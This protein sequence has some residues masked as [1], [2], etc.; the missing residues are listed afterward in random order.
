[1]W[2]VAVQEV[3]VGSDYGLPADIYSFGI[4]LWEAWSHDGAGGGCAGL[5]VIL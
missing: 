4:V 1:M 2:L 3:L 5:G